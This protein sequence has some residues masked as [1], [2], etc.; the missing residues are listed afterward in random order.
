MPD[1]ATSSRNFIQNKLGS[2]CCDPVVPMQCDYVSFSV[3]IFTLSVIIVSDS[4]PLVTIGIIL[5]AIQNT[6]ERGQ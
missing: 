4:R 3:H 6:V 2:Q 1:A 5:H